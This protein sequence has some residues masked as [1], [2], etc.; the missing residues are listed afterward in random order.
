MKNYRRRFVARPYSS[1]GLRFVAFSRSVAV[2][3]LI[4]VSHSIAV[5]YSVVVP[6]QAGTQHH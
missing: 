2:S 6:A 3:C 4:A 1:T 5:S